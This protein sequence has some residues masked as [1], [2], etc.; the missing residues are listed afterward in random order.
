[1]AGVTEVLI[2]YAR[3]DPP[4]W[5]DAAVFLA[6]PTPRAPEVASWRPAAAD[7]LRRAWRGPGRL[8]VFVP[9][10]P[11]GGMRGGGVQGFGPDRGW[12]EQVAWEDRC[13]ELAD[14]IAFW[15]PRDPAT[16]PGF[17]TNVEFGRWERSG[18]VVLGAPPG[19]PHTRYLR[20]YAA[21]HGAP[22]A[23]TLDGTL[24]AALAAV[25]AGARRAGAERGVPLHVW[26]IESFQH[27][28]AAQRA[29]G[30]VLRDARVGWTL[31]GL[32]GLHYWVL[33]AQVWVA[34]EDRVKA[35]EVV[36][37]RPDVA[38]VALYLP[39]PSLARTQVVLVREFRV[40]VRTADGYVHELP[41]GSGTGEPREVAAEEVREET[42]LSIAPERLRYHGSR[43]VAG[44]VSAHHA[45]L[46]SAE[47]T[48][49]ELA[50]LR[51]AA[52]SGTA[53]GDPAADERTFVE[54]TTVDALLRD[55]T[56]DWST[57]GMLLQ[58]LGPG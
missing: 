27:W 40:S 54:V 26:R 8:V 32:A 25:G 19:A 4:Q 14:V 24:A 28:Y 1:M 22:V 7:L 53:F 3:R 51:S 49:R 16:L 20:H 41:G 31:P 44:T 37:A 9:E 56:V 48:P 50:S 6:G 35:N 11:G 21:L 45:H 17:T 58:A 2:A 10:D 23:D 12:A 55:S 30:N 38:A 29:T 34:A 42:G 43:Q 13:L 39:G 36:L 46:F 15:V 47:L 52:A 18:K 5:W 57:L 33:H